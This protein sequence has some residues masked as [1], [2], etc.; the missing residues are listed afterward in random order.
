MKHAKKPNKKDSD[1]RQQVRRIG[2]QFLSHVE[3]GAQEAAYLVLQMPLRKSSR[4]VVF[5]DT[6]ELNNR[7]VLLKPY[8]SLK[9][10][11][12]SSTNVESDNALKRYKRRPKQMSKYCYADFVTWFDTS[13]EKCKK[14]VENCEGE[15][16]EEDYSHDLEDD[17]LAS[18]ES[19]EDT[20]SFSHN[21]QTL[22]EF[23]DGT[24]MKKRKKQKVLRYHTIALNVDR[25]GHYRQLLM[26]FTKWRKEE[27][28]L[29]HGCHTYE[30]SY[31]K[32]KDE[33]EGVKARYMKISCEIGED[34]LHDVDDMDDYQRNVV[35]PE[36]EHQET[37]DSAQGSTL[38]DNFGCFDPGTESHCTG[39]VSNNEYDI[40]Q[41]FGIARKRFE[42]ESLPMNEMSDNNYRSLVQS[43]NEKQK[44]FFYNVLNHF[45]T[46]ET[47]LYTFLTG[48]AG[49]GKSV[50]LR[51]LYQALIKYFNHKV[52][53]NP[54]NLKV[55][56]CAPTGKAA[57]NIGGNTIHSAFGI[58]VGRGFAFKPLDMH[59]L[60]S[61]RCRFFHLKIVFID[62]ISMVGKRM[63]NFINLRLQ[64]IK[65]CCK[66]FGGV[67]VIVF[68]DLYQLKP[69]MDS[70]IFTIPRVGIESI[71]ANLW[72]DHFT[73]FELE[74]IMRQ[75]D[76]KSF[77]QLLNRLREGNHMIPQ[78]IQI[79]Q[80]RLLNAPNAIHPPDLDLI[81][82]LFTTR[83]ECDLHNFHLLT[84]LP[85]SM[86][87]VVHS[88]DSVSGDVP[89]SLKEKI[90]NKVPDD[91]G[92]TMGLQKNLHLAIGPPYELCLNV[93]VEDGLTNGASCSIKMFD[94]R[95][96]SSHHRVSIVWVEFENSSSGCQWRQKYSS[97]Y[98]TNI[99]HSWTPI[100]EVT[101]CFNIQHYKT[102]NVVRRQF[103]L[104]MSA[105]KTIHKAQGSTM[106]SAVLHFG[107]R[108]NDHI[109][110][111]GL[112]RIKNLSNLFIKELNSKKISICSDVREEMNR[113][114][115]TS[116]LQL[117]LP[118]LSKLN[119]NCALVC[120]HNCRSLRK[121]IDDL[122]TDIYLK[123]VDILALCETRVFE[124]DLDLN[125]EGLSL[126]CADQQQS[127][128]G[129]ALYYKPNIV[130][131]Q[132]IAT[133]ISGIELLITILDVAN[134]C[135]IYCPPKSATNQ[136]FANVMQYLQSIINITK[137]TIIMGDFN[138]NA[139]QNCS[140]LN[141]LQHN[142]SFH[143]ILK[144][145]TT[146]Y[147]SCLDHIY[148][149]F[150]QDR[151]CLS[152]T[153]ESYYSDHKPIY[154]S[155]IS[156][157]S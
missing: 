60:D 44:L 16:L 23:R 39:T 132:L 27:T 73:I 2:N 63:F 57:H 156:E 69:V 153:L 91:A 71:G 107:S 33:V 90:L 104:Q 35:L 45:K 121:H 115:T 150:P 125:I 62:E 89:C 141:F 61:M 6:N 138:Q 70:W 93:S 38:S 18:A 96:D 48:G 9:D 145:P 17:I 149:N 151:L 109:H 92:K 32:V 127:K 118:D 12:E 131:N 51:S 108:K 113:M 157:T 28:D 49:V 103:P 34:M 124:S 98:T 50:L 3:I 68:G 25:E 52:G 75:K 15:L 46:N 116:P 21:E 128:H 154:L 85:D 126:F 67:S 1:I 79:L 29:L 55:L 105:A 31:T 76:D 94:Y 152:G 114:T 155:V 86:K 5:I 147:D 30:E 140:V 53:E 87:A 24:I 40:G 119:N 134:I 47:P 54:D 74:E 136:N 102:Y 83:A 111:V 148:I 100:L 22:F 37:I 66:P 143:Q 20:D 72:Q 137:P 13:L 88:I 56:L 80:S 58:P 117:R 78:D 59:Q 8:S 81:P 142:Y 106:N 120:F 19:N 84:K 130:Q 97:L 95:V 42:N 82:H 10:M 11:P 101:R 26:L 129:M 43:L 110:Y 7:T 135:F 146:D 99:P 41:D 64:E 112:S 144:S 133:S 36:N 123:H 77:A 14:Q 139:F 122:R 4:E 65:G